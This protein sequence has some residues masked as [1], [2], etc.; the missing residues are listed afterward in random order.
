MSLTDTICKGAKP[1]LKPYKLADSQGL[2]LHVMP[3]G[4]KYWRI[5]FRYLKKEKLFAAGKYPE[6]SLADAREKVR[7]IKKQLNNNIDPSRTKKEQK[8]EALKQADNI[9]QNVAE[10]WMNTQ[11]ANWTPK[12]FE[13]VKRRLENDIFPYIGDLPISKIALTDLH[14]AIKKIEERDALHLIKKVRQHCG[15]IFTY[16]MLLGMCSHNPALNL[17]RAYK[18]KKTKHHAA[19]EYS[20]IPKFLEKLSNNDNRLYPRTIRAIRLSLL[21]FVRPGELR[22]AKW[23]EIDLEKKEWKLPAIAMKSRRD[24]IVPLSDQAVDIFKKQKIETGHIKTDYVFPHL[25]RPKEPMTDG[26]V[27]MALHRLGFKDTMTAHGFRALARTTIREQ[28]GIDADIIE[29]QLAHKPSNSLGEAYDRAKFL[30]QR[31]DMMQKWADY[32]DRIT[33]EAKNKVVAFKS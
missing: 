20:E 3:N 6:V 4:S 25:L 12:Y 31:K 2:Y 1:K 27:R 9:F 5:K 24:F 13:T 17:Q 10:A 28:L 19:F 22:K 8:Q 26:T 11:K 32:I 7:E 16:A 21:L 23:S 30:T 14:H 18:T 29:I 15:Q 33:F